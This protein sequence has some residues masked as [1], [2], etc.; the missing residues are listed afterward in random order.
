MHIGL[1]IAD[2]AAG[3]DVGKHQR[4][5]TVADEVAARFQ[6]ILDHLADEGRR[7]IIVGRRCR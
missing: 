3:G 1:V 5:G 6:E 7:H 4:A 2:E